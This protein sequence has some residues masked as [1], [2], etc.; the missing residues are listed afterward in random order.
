MCGSES[1]FS[2]TCMLKLKTVNGRFQTSRRSTCFFL[3]FHKPF[4][5]CRCLTQYAEGNFSL[6]IFVFKFFKFFQ[7]FS[8]IFLQ[9]ILVLN[10]KNAE[11]IN[12]IYFSNILSLQAKKVGSI[13]DKITRTRRLLSI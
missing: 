8:F 4:T 2:S 10:V 3:F 13:F 9:T 11:E 6:E 5:S 7:F 12:L 1:A